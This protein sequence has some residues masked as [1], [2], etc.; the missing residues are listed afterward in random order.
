[1]SETPNTVEGIVLVVEDDPFLLAQIQTT[2]DRAGF[3]TASALTR[4]EVLAFIEEN[5][6][7]AIVLDLGLP[8]D[9]GLSITRAVRKLS[10][11]PIL[12]LTGRVGVASR[13]AGLEAG[14]DDYLLKPHAPE[15]LV[16]RLRAI[17]RRTAPLTGQGVPPAAIKIGQTR[18]DLVSGQLR[19]K[20]RQIHLTTQECRLVIALAQ[21][22]GILSRDLA[23]RQV[24]ARDWVAGDR[25]LDVHMAN[26]RRKFGTVGL[27]S[28]VIST[29]RGQGYA[30]QVPVEIEAAES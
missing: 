14:A 28:G 11:V 26:L 4:H 22:G 9:D 30:F 24:F 10:Q 23:Y 20:D 7:Q 17:L 5:K 13:V 2:L 21:S 8:V 16:A 3:Q 15:E 27:S 12:M 19:A 29:V 18:L 1:M 25:S 6:C